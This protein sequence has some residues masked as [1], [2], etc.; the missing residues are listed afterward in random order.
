MDISNKTYD[1]LQLLIII[2]NEISLVGNK[3][4][5]FIDYRLC[6]IKKVHRKFMDGLDL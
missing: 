1:Q 2:I 6:V 5:A 4:F 3:M